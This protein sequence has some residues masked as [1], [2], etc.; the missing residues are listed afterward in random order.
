MALRTRED[1]LSSLK[2][3][4]PNVY[5]FGKLIEDVTTHPA[6]RRVVESHARGIDA[7]HDPELSE[8]FTTTSNLTGET[9][10]VLQNL[11]D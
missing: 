7:A 5:K 3:L 10:G 8:I 1:Y 4:R 9:I 6:T 11:P 2:S